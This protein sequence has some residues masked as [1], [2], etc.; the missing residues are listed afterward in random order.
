MSDSVTS[1]DAV[2][3]R[4]LSPARQQAGAGLP[5]ASGASS[6]A[7][8]LQDGVRTAYSPQP[9]RGRGQ[10]GGAQTPGQSV[11]ERGKTSPQAG[12]DNGDTPNMEPVQTHGGEE[13]SKARDQPA[14]SDPDSRTGEVHEGGSERRKDSPPADASGA[15]ELGVA[16]APL[17]DG[18]AQS[19]PAAEGNPKSGA[20]GTSGTSVGA[21]ASVASAV[22]GEA[23]QLPSSQAEAPAA[24]GGDAIEPAGTSDPPNPPAR[25]NEPAAQP[26]VGPPADATKDKP[27]SPTVPGAAPNVQSTPG[28]AVTGNA[29]STSRAAARSDG[30]KGVG[31][32]KLASA[33]QDISPGADAKSADVSPRADTAPPA[34]NA[35]SAP[36]PGTSLDTAKGGDLN[37]LAN[38]AQVPHSADPQTPSSVSHQA[39]PGSPSS[40]PANASILSQLAGVGQGTP[41]RLQA[42]IDPTLAG[43]TLGTTGAAN[44][45]GAVSSSASGLFHTTYSVSSSSWPDDLGSRV[46][47]MVDQ[48]VSTADLTLNPPELGK[49]QV[50]V[51]LEDDTTKVSF[52]VH[53]GAARQ[54]V[55]GTL[56]RLR[57]MF[58]QAGV[59]LQ[60]VDVTE[61]HSSANQ[62]GGGSQFDQSG[63]A[64]GHDR[65]GASIA[66]QPLPG[67]SSR[68]LTDSVIDAYA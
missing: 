15:Q 2:G 10:A 13:A 46:I 20:D 22:T 58:Q 34:S 37:K 23:Q 21:A 4:G 50:R 31:A 57:E 6:F 24:Q 18:A 54:A 41:D 68:V 62:G 28:G 11:A 36:N 39:D 63:T 25:G 1:F 56:P 5:Q 42:P 29:V 32:H 12:R 47:W 64:G 44:H 66:L 48:K 9:S 45:S 38:T 61:H 52:N 40:A 14:S 59:N 51:S 60:H 17:P 19:P 3:A 8:M 35:V 55:E 16:A 33:A 53:N 67:V 65:S 27:N 26:A 7:S 30:T 49:V 43:A